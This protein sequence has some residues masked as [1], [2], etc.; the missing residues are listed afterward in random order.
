[1][2]PLKYS[3]IRGNWATLLLPINED[4]SIDYCLLAEEIDKLIAC[5]VN[6][7]Y[8]NGTAGEFYNQT[9]H[10]FDR[11]SEL[12]AEQC[13]R[14]KIAFQIGVSHTSPVISYERLQRI[15]PLAPGAVQLIV[16]DWYPTSMG[17]NI[18]FMHKMVDCAGDIG[19]VLY[20]PPHAKQC[21]SPNEFALLK[22]AVPSFVG[23]KVAGGDGEWFRQMKK[24]VPDI[25][26]F[27]P[28]H[29]LASGIKQGA[30]GS[31][32][33]VACLNPRAA[34]R[35]YEQVLVNMDEALQQEV[36][37]QQFINDHIRPY[38][39]EYH[40]SNQAIDKLLACIGGWTQIT[41]RLRWPYRSI[42]I[43]DVQKLKKIAESMLSEFFV[44]D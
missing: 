33:N 36:R 20:N 25:S 38:I 12:L 26:V 32:S 21:L 1:M 6:G 30:H 10:E 28:G 14:A 41:P 5:R 16:P 18:T 11:I 39:S 35:W 27:I 24:L 3:E 13:N 42:P 8:S 4:E 19:L 34:Q 37:I 23:I 7:I 43:E 40:Y 22:Q 15:I 17:E 29:T 31:Y 2:K 9:E 44:G